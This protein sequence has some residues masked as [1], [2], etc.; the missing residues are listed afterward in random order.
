MRYQMPGVLRKTRLFV[1]VLSIFALLV[2]LTSN[3]PGISAA[4]NALK[5]VS[6]AA[7]L[8]SQVKAKD[9]DLAS[10][11]SFE[12]SYGKLPLSFEVNNGQVDDSVKFLSRG[13]GYTLFLTST[14]AVLSLRRG[15][16]KEK[17][18]TAN[19][20]RAADESKPTAN[21][22]VR[23]KAIGANPNPKISGLDEL[24]GKSNYFI[25]N[26][27]AKWRTG[28]SNYGKVK[29][30]DVYPGIDLVYYG[31]QRQLEYDWIV[32]PGADPKTIRFAVDGKADLK[33][34]S[35]GNLI[36]DEKGELRLNKPVIYQDHAGV[37]TH[38]AGTYALLDKNA[39][40]FHL[41][42]YDVSL[43]LVIDPI[44][45]YSTYLGGSK[46]D[47]SKAIAVDSSGN[48]YVAG[49]TGSIDF[50]TANPLQTYDPERIYVY[51]FVTKLNASGN[52]LVY[53]TY[54]GGSVG[55]EAFAIAVDSSG[56]AYVTGW[57]ISTDFPMANPFQA[58]SGGGDE[59]FVVKLNTSGNSL[60]YSTYLGGSGHDGPYA[61]AVDSSGN[62]YVTG[63]TTSADFP[64]ANPFQSSIG[65]GGGY[66]AFVTKL[67]ASGNSLIYSTYL[68]GS[69]G[70]TGY[71]IAAD[72]S[73]NAYV[74]GMVDSTN[75]PTVNPLQASIGGLINAFV[76]KLDA[77]GNSLVYSTYLG[78]N[79]LDM[80]AAIA[81]DSSGN[82]YVTGRTYSTNFPIANPLQ[83]NLS[84]GGGYDAFITKLDA[85]GTSLVY[86]TYLGGN[87][88]D[89]AHGIAVDSSGN[90]YLTGNSS[91]TDFPRVN[92]LEDD[93][94]CRT[95]VSKL[96][97]LGNALVYST[98]FGGS[99]TDYANAIAVDSSGNAYVTGWTISTDFPTAN[100]FQT[101]FSGGDSD[102]FITKIGNTTLLLRD[103][104][105]KVDVNWL[106][107]T[108]SSGQGAAVP[109][110]SDSGYF[111]FFED[112]NVELLVK[113]HDG[114]GVNGHF[115][116]F[117]GALTDV[118]YTI[119][120]TDTQTSAVKTYYGTQHYQTSA[121]DVN[122]FACP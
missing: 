87:G 94:Y 113:I 89:E 98:C 25:G 83:A 70:E 15:S 72:P 29:L 106:A 23:L 66:D 58:N 49:L 8:D 10:R 13:N 112:T 46:R 86:S 93:F 99:S 55:D 16:A 5:G 103:G 34:D 2:V 100:P 38:I 44:L 45:S 82:A 118:E 120:V 121:N 52:A 27:P 92:S 51:A 24:P 97:T 80:G 117:Y 1:T 119:T 18:Q 110:T 48:A 19:L 7:S 65:G 39:V 73:G 60:I 84:G 53:S 68:G 47:H 114:C 17:D 57:T 4:D 69:N 20:N 79:S 54:L 63:D 21:E 30:A 107:P 116:F 67:D 76:T 104:R 22:V 33:I 81:V 75:F 41:D 96:S 14:E 36:L 101:S 95:F 12:R 3:L 122:A 74:T 62:A 109:L 40:G 11:A 77:S 28:V 56:N 9:V 108:G 59:G 111:W 90:A 32:K 64:T 91:S 42:K 6:T 50:P 102:A 31:N 37:R 35:Q 88:G 43:P 71:G 26:D 61:I 105:F 78:G 115:W 85:S